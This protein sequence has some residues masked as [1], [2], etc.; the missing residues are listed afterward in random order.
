M[1]AFE[2]VSWLNAAAQYFGNRPTNGEDKAHWANV[3]NAEACLKIAELIKDICK[4]D[5][6][7]NKEC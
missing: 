5:R 2:A 7:S 6:V 1:T 4:D 3:Y